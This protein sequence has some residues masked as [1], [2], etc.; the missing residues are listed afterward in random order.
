MDSIP[1]LTIEQVFLLSKGGFVIMPDFPLVD[2]FSKPMQLRA[3]IENGIGKSAPCTLELASTHYNIPSSSDIMKRWRL[4]P[5]VSDIDADEISI[6]DV[7]HIYD[8]HIAK[9]LRDLS[10]K[11]A[12]NPSI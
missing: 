12:A 7:L 4:T 9:V 11:S 1:I 5:I 2:S 3:K 6:G 10:C 8:R